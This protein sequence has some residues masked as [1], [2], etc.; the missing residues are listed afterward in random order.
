MNY[1]SRIHPEDVQNVIGSRMLADGLDMVLDLEKSKGMRLY[2]SRKNRYLLDFFGFFASN[3]VGLNHPALFDHDFL[4]DLKTASLSKV[5]NSDIYTT[6]M[7]EFVDTLSREATPDYMKYFFFVEGGALAVENALKTAFDWKVRKNNSNGEKKEVG[8]KIMHLKEAFHGRSG[9]TL[10]LTNTHDPRKTMYFPKFDW[11]R[12]TNPKL[13]FPLTEKSIQEVEELEK[14]SLAEMEQNFEKYGNDIA[15]FIMEPIQGEGGDNHFR[16]EYF[17]AVSKLVRQN[18]ALLIMDEVQSGMG[19]TGKWW[20]H[21]HFD[22]K[23]DIM[24]FGKKSQVCGIMVGS[25]IDE[26]KDNVFKTSSRINSTWGGN[27]ADMIRAKRYIEIIKDESLVQN[28]DKVGKIMVDELT[29]LAEEFPDMMSNARGRGLM[30]A[31]DL[32]SEK[33]R[34]EF[35][36]RMFSK[37]ILTL[38]AGALTIR[39]R[40]PL[41]ASEEDVKEFSGKV[42]EVLKEMGATN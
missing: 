20:A 2:D 39:L 13:K 36:D 8:T 35:Y 3:P 41:I 38:K 42:R 10:S 9:Y 28:A 11:P 26:V 6:Q 33:F 7:A 14:K 19:M 5:T 24:A 4:E 32:K 25:K 15:A 22:V 31:F 12:V 23:P 1:E 29:G 27:L 40:P 21:Q 37:G 34:D 16:K 30:D 18:E 17:D